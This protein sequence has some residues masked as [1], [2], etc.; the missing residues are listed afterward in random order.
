M[1]GFETAP[2][3]IRWLIRRDMPEVFAIENEAFGLDAW[4]EQEFI[5]TLR[6]R[7]CIGLVAEHSE[8][9]VGYMLYL[10]LPRG[11]EVINFA[12][13]AEF[14]RRG[15]GRQMI[16]KLVGKMSQKRTR[17][18]AMVRESNLA[19]LNFFKACG[20]RAVRLRPGYFSDC[21]DDAIEM[22]ITREDYLQRSAAAA[23]S[24]G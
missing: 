20:L 7:N 19:A 16:E 10:L 12:V 6:G 1:N 17:V 14:R 4:R 11:F 2:V 21:E 23:A 18:S 8:R 24:L 9:I 13:H 15:V 3:H 5:D 22:R